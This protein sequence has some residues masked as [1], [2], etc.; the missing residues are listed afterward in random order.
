LIPSR[1]HYISG[2]FLGPYV[3]PTSTSGSWPTVAENQSFGQLRS[4]AGL[5]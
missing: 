5:A 4:E 2:A 3:R 1:G